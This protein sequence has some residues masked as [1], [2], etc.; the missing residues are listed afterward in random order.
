MIDAEELGSACRLESPPRSRASASQR[1]WSGERNRA[2][3]ILPMSWIR[4]AVKLSGGIGVRDSARDWLDGERAGHRVA[5]QLAV[6]QAVLGQRA[7]QLLAKP[8]GGGEGERRPDADAHDRV[9]RGV[10]GREAGHRRG[11]GA[12]QQTA[13]Q[14]GVELD[15]M[16]RFV[17]RPVGAHDERG[18]ARHR[19]RQRV[20]AVRGL[21]EGSG[22]D[23]QDREPSLGRRRPSVRSIGGGR[24][25]QQSSSGV[26][27]DDDPCRLQ[28]VVDG[29][30]GARP[31][32]PGGPWLCRLRPERIVRRQ[33]E[34]QERGRTQ[35]EAAGRDVALAD[36][37]LMSRQAD[38]QPA[39]AS[40]VP[41]ASSVR[42]STADSAAR[43]WP[44]ATPSGSA[45]RSAICARS[46]KAPARYAIDRP[47]AGNVPSGPMR[48]SCTRHG[49]GPGP[50][51]AP[52]WPPTPGSARAFAS[53]AT[54]S[55]TSSSIGWM[56]KLL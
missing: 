14:R 46:W 40:N 44:G 22:V 8:R 10:D 53:G 12:P 45:R 20:Q 2:R 50:A 47:I 9:A 4:A 48:R 30:R 27:P 36:A 35:I 33:A 43:T 19:R 16:G 18:Q 31:G 5:P 49:A 37:R 7:P 55:R 13:G 28:R 29:E 41:G 23:H 24:R 56:T 6:G 11:V 38:A 52:A 39:V 34:R 42:I 25:L 17:Q 51:P 21:H 15:E 32:Q 26:T 1:S 54:A 3:T